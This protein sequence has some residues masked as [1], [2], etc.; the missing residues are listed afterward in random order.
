MGPPHHWA[1]SA[2]D[3]SVEMGRWGYNDPNPVG[4]SEGEQRGGEYGGLIR[5]KVLCASEGTSRMSHGKRGTFQGRLHSS[6][7]V[8]AKLQH[9]NTQPK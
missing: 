1:L 6:Q 4:V 2:F 5:E 9:Q 3:S 7:H 8:R